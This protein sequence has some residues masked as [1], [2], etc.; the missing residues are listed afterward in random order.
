MSRSSI[1]SQMYLKPM[2]V[3]KIFRPN[4]A[5]ILSSIFVDENVFATSPGIPRVPARCQSR[6]EK[7]W[8]GVINVPSRSIAPMR[9]PSP[10]AHSPA[11]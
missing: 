11:W 6:I 3:S 7:I 2:G 5:A 1:S 10:S 8:C 4:F 9:S